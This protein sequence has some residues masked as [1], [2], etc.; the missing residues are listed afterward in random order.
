MIPV[1][2]DMDMFNDLS[3]H[4]M[5]FTSMLSA[6][7]VSQHPE[8][9]SNTSNWGWSFGG[10]AG[11]DTSEQVQAPAEPHAVARQPAATDEGTETSPSA[12]RQPSSDITSSSIPLHSPSAALAAPV[13][14]GVA[15]A[16]AQHTE[17]KVRT[18]A[19]A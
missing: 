8:A 13:R 17:A 6:D 11:W 1:P 15:A 12:P 5:D 3:K 18:H 19:A 14:S 4:A 16:S 10:L 7:K 2:A 9:T